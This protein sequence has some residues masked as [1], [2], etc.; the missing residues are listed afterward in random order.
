MGCEATG[1]LQR[2][3]ELLPAGQMGVQERGEE[4]QVP[5]LEDGHVEREESR[6]ER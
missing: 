3:R 5:G 4:A 2:C 6:G 1:G